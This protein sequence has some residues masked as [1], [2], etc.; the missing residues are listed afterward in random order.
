MNPFLHGTAVIMLYIVVAA[1]IMLPARKLI[2]IPDELFRKILHFVSIIG[3]V[4]VKS[5]FIR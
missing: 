4:F 1:G 3:R 2:K 5:L